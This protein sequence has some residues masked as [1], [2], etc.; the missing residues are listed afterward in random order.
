MKNYEITIRIIISFTIIILS[1]LLPDMFPEFFG[2][3]Y[4]MGYIPDGIR[5]CFRSPG[6]HNPEWHYGYR[7]WIFISMGLS[8]FIQQV[9]YV[10]NKLNKN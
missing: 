9:F 1:S 4:C 10:G 2:D 7:H 8:L 3:T 6:Y 5:L